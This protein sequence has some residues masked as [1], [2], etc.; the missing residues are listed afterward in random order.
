LLFCHRYASQEKLHKEV[1]I[2]F[3]PAELYG[4]TTKRLNQQVVR[5]K[6]RFPKDFMFR[7]TKEETEALRLQF[8]TSSLGHAGRCYLPYAFTELGVAMLSSVL[9]SDQVIEVISPSWER[10]Y[11]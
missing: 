4:V 2:D 10:S 1:M 9:N 7:L 11:D 8:A 3:D 5:N 6:K